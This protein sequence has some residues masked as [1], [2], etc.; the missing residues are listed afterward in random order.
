MTTFVQLHLLTSYPPANLNRDDTGQ[1]KTAIMG[2]AL[3]GRVSSQSLKRAW[4]TSEVFATALAGHVGTR[5]KRFAEGVMARLTA[6]GR[7]ENEARKVAS[8]IA[9]IFATVDKETAPLTGQLV[10]LTPA[11][12]GAIDELAK[13]LRAGETVEIAHERLLSRGEGAADIAMFGR[14]LADRPD[15][16]VEA[17]AQ[18]AH[19]ITS[20]RV[21]IEDDYFTA[22]DDLK[23]R[24]EDAGAG[25]VGEQEFVAGL[26]YLYVCV[27]RDLL[28][29]N[30]GGDAPLARTALRA[31]TEAAV[32]VGPRGKQASFA[33]RAY[34]SLALA[35]RGSQQPRGLSLA[36]LDPIRPRADNADVA[37]LSM[38]ALWKIRS[39]MEAAYG[40]CA[41]DYRYLAVQDCKPRHHDPSKRVDLAGLLDFVGA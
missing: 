11:E 21:T 2:G 23:P 41:D 18:V 36:F 38:R 33:S 13:R 10:H 40:A 37:D 4:R 14:M 9:A 16:S 8:D 5:T 26:F 6:A 22:V 27:D 1:P 31:L 25:H 32:K 7:D 28:V 24:G 34:A 12:L 17:A 20:H 30:L 35:E 19:A 15:H 39:R 3:R 29:R